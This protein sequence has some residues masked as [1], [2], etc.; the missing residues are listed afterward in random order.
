MRYWTK[1]TQIRL[2]PASS[3]SHRVKYH[4]CCPPSHWSLFYILPWLY[5]TY[6]LTSDGTLSCRNSKTTSPIM[7][8]TLWALQHAEWVAI[9]ENWVHPMARWLVW[10]NV[11]WKDHPKGVGA[12]LVLVSQSSR[13]DQNESCESTRVLGLTSQNLLRCDPMQPLVIA[14]CSLVLW[15]TTTAFAST[16]VMPGLWHP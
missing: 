16:A 3:W 7:V 14:A 12:I 4:M 11:L 6:Y 10:V 8:S 5:I 1:R 13:M 9:G 15:W 2:E